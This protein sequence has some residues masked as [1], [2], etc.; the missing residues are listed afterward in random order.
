MFEKGFTLIE[1][2]V[3]VAIISLLSSIVYA[4]VSSARHKAEVA[5]SNVEMKELKKGFELSSLNASDALTYPVLQDFEGPIDTP[6]IF[7]SISEYVDDISYP[8]SIISPN[9]EYYYLSDGDSP[10]DSS[11]NTYSCG[12]DTGSGFAIY[13]KKFAVAGDTV[14]KSGNALFLDGDIVAWAEEGD[15]DSYYEASGCDTAAN[16]VGCND[17][18]FDPNNLPNPCYTEFSCGCGNCALCGPPTLTE[19]CPG[20]VGYD[21][22]NADPNYY[23]EGVIIPGTCDSF[24]F[25]SDGAGYYQ[26]I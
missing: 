24:E 13:Y 7:S 14:L 1:L 4:S 2:L 22:C 20:D 17:E 9:Q 25:I 19:Y 5:R 10:T 12:Q 21:A 16:V 3:V 6:G 18:G 11:S 15:P 23:A 26:C 8:S